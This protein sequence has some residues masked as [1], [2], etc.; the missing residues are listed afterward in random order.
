MNRV[1]S[2]FYPNNVCGVVYQNA[3]RH[4][5]C[6]FTFACDGIPDVVDEPDMWDAGQGDFARHAR[7]QAVAAGD[8]PLHALP[9]LLGAPGAGS[10]K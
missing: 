7:R 1:F 3:N 6:Q 5:A 9:R 2:G 4:Y 8:R 10:T